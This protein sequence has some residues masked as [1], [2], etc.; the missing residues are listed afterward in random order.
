MAQS[1]AGESGH[2]VISMDSHTEGLVGLKPYLE[3]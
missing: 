1:L 3:T 2:I